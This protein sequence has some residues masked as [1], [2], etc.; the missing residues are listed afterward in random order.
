M[1]MIMEILLKVMLMYGG[2]E[3]CKMWPTMMNMMITLM[4]VMLM[5]GGCA[6]CGQPSPTWAATAT[7]S[8]AMRQQAG[9]GYF[10]GSAC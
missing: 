1:M 6:R 9:A 7:G 10:I 3:L 5:H 8:K 2:C 4:I